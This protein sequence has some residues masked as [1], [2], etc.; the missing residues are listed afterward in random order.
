M[1]ICM[2]TVWEPLNCI[3]VMCMCTICLCC[4]ELSHE[5]MG[6]CKYTHL[7]NCGTSMAYIKFVGSVLE[8]FPNLGKW[9][10]TACIID[11]IQISRMDIVPIEKKHW[12]SV[13]SSGSALNYK[14]SCKCLKDIV[15]MSSNGGGWGKPD[16]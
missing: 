13:W 3:N 6:Y 11:F 7:F 1:N 16:P 5:Y 10:P 2:P 9:F 4:G 12:N 14:M 8:S 15:S